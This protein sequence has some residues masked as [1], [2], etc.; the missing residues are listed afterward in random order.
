MCKYIYI[1]ANNINKY[2]TYWITKQY[3][4]SKFVNYPN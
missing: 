4:S 3:E 1:E 2:I